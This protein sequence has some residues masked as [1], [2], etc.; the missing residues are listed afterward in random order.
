LFENNRFD[1]DA[2]FAVPCQA[3]IQQLAPEEPIVTILDDTLI[4]KK[5]RK[6]AGSSWHHD[7]LG[8]PFAHQ[9]IW[10]QRA[11]ELCA[12]LPAQ[13]GQP[14]SARAIPIDLTLQPTPPKYSSKA[15]D[16]QRQFRRQFRQEN[17][18]PRLGIQRVTAL[19]KMMDRAGHSKRKLL[20]A[21]D[22]GYTNKTLLTNLPANTALIGRIRKDANLCAPPS[23]NLTGRGRPKLYGKPLETPEQL[24]HN[25]NVEWKSVEAFAAGKTR[26]FQ[27]KS[28]DCCRWAKGAGGRNL[29]LVVV[30]PLSQTPHHAGRRLFFAHPGYLICSDPEIDINQIIQP[31][32]WRWEIEVGFREQ[33]THLGLGQPQCRNSMAVERVIQFQAFVYALLLL[34]AY[35]SG[36]SA[37]PRPKWQPRPST[38]QRSS[39]GQIISIL[40]AE[41]WGQALG[42][43]NKT[44]FVTTALPFPKSTKITNTLSS[45]VLYASQ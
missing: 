26:L 34:A 12:M 33:K 20:L 5:G 32:V 42:L 17:A 39:I 44:H 7:S 30:R 3:V 22:G 2:L 21:V 11:I 45:A 10:S 6:V 40:R 31:Y 38:Q 1:P 27:Y 4:P 18:I 15:T 19:R 9:I 14:C 24:L 37:P 23:P 35:R 25:P 29:R 41:L 28:I 36:V 43:E 8:P 16:S 13:P